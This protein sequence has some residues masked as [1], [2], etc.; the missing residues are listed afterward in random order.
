M[1]T[2]PEFEPASAT[3]PLAHYRDITGRIYPALLNLFHVSTLP[4]QPLQIMESPAA[5]AYMAPA[6]YYLAGSTDSNAPRPGIFYVNTSELKTRRT[7][8]CQAL[9]LHEA[10]VCLVVA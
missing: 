10:L 5:S 3:E 2:S 8:E 9:A 4:R 6:A 7:Y 1:R